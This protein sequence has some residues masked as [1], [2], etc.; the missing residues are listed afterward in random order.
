MSIAVAAEYESTIKK[1]GGA[2]LQVILC[3]TYDDNRLLPLT[4]D[5]PICLLPIA[6][7]KLL[8]YQLELL[9]QC[10]ATGVV[11]FHHFSVIILTTSLHRNI[12]CDTK[13]I[14]YTII[15]IHHSLS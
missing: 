13:R 4:E 5:C 1:K 10:G 9:K 2:S 8:G 12:C 6:N 15:T 3:V 14:L 11:P 7:R